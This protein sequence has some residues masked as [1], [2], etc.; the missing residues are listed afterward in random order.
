MAA[1]PT[2]S[3]PL[4]QDYIIEIPELDGLQ[5]IDALELLLTVRNGSNHAARRAASTL[6]LDYVCRTWRRTARC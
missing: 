6:Q 1:A 4:S 3:A 2:S 5:L